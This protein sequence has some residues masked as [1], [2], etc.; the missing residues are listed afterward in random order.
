MAGNALSDIKMVELGDFMA[1][2]YCTKLMADLGAEV[3][4]IEEPGTGDS[5]RRYGP[6][7]GDE[8]HP[9][10]SLLFA[11]MNSNKQ[12]ITLDVK[13]PQGKRVFKELLR[14]TDVLVESNPPRLME[15]LGLD[16]S[17]LARVNPGLIVTSITPFGQTGPYRDYKATDLVSFHIGGIGYPTPGDVDDP[18]IFPPLKAPGHQTHIMSGITGAAATMAAIFAR[19]FTG[20][21]QHVDVSEQETLLREIGGAVVSHVNRGETPIRIAGM[22]RPIASR[23]PL[24]AKDGYFTCQLLM[25]HF[26]ES[27]KKVLGYPEWANSEIFSER[28]S[29]GPPRFVRP[30]SLRNG[31]RTTRE[32]SFTRYSRWKTTCPASR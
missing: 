8:P 2:P 6:F 16:Y 9:E 5:A 14:D 15:E 30:P 25:D 13:G 1:A 18:D 3:I 12:G 4:K 10:K 28:Q 24:L 19:E 31:L 26:W 29:P 32:R 7:P 11:Y 23:K 27:L 20:R 17:S 21:G 22:G